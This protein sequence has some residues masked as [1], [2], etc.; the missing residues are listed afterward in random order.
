ME[1]RDLRIYLAVI[2]W[3]GFSRA[4]DHIG[5]VQSGVSDAVGRLERELGV[6][7]L[8]RRRG[9]RPTP[10]GEAL[11]RWARILSKGE[12]RAVREISELRD[13]GRGRVSVGMLPTIAPLVLPTLVHTLGS[14]HPRIDI[15]CHEG[16]AP[17]LI[18]RVASAALDLAV[19]FFPTPP[20]PGIEMMPVAARPLFVICP[21]GHVLSRR[22]ELA[23]IEASEERWVSFPPQNPGRVWL[24][25]AC[26]QA[27]F[28]PRIAVE[29]ETA[30]HQ[31][32]FVGAGKG[33]A[34]VP[35][36]PWPDER[37][38]VHTI[39]LR[40]P[41]PEFQI[42]YAFDRWQPGPAVEATRAVLHQLLLD[43]P[44]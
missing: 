2:E 11:A 37:S 32:A 20:T 14:S 40:G 18:E 9:V 24:E 29:V 6:K 31:R 12:E 5:M 4:S 7:I 15:S 44:V 23:L 26:A 1:L 25:Q 38:R 43:L 22:R 36:E 28:R 35:F 17:E 34:M 13:V 41:L 19:I 8:D 21:P 10:A 30:S 27:G 3:G 33:L 42:G 39:R 16:L